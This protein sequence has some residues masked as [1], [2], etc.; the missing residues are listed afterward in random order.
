VSSIAGSKRSASCLTSTQNVVSL[1]ADGQM[2]GRCPNAGTIHRA[3]LLRM[4][5]VWG[6]DSAGSRK[7]SSWAS[8]PHTC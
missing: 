7:R 8:T 4:T 6:I 1:R 3:A 2:Y 5:D